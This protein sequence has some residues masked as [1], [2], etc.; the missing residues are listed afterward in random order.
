MSGEPS[1]GVFLPAKIAWELDSA[2]RQIPRSLDF[3]ECY[4]SSQG[5]LSE[6][7]HVFLAGNRL[8][9]RLARVTK[10][11]R[12][13]I[14]ETGFGVALNFLATVKL[15]QECGA[16]GHLHYV[17]TEVFGVSSADLAQAHLS[18]PELLA[19]SQPLIE[20]YPSLI[21]GVHRLHFADWNVTLDLWF[22][23][24]SASLTN[25]V[26]PNGVDAWFLDGFSPRQ[27]LDLW[28]SAVFD[29]VARLSS[30]GTTAATYSAARAV[31]QGLLL[32]LIHI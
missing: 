6:T 8:A 20:Q 11:T 3:D 31:K 10:G 12:F 32:S 2:G 1:S 23:E 9:E 13:V 27:N 16:G 7:Q 17:S 19:F 15:W 21:P 5:G 30:A 14:A 28:A 24:A 26:A 18:F 29:Q 22:G 25:L 4:F